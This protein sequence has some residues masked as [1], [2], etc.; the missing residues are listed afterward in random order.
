MLGP[1][2]IDLDT[3]LLRTF[4]AIAESESF[5]QAAETVHRSQAAVSQQMHRLEAML[6][7]DL[8]VK[9]GRSKQLTDQGVT[10]LEYARRILKLNDQAYSALAGG[11]IETT[12]KL[13]ACADAIDTLLPEYLALSTATYPNLDIKIMVGRSRWLARSLQRGD[14]DIMLDVEE[15]PQF[16]SYLLRTSPVVWISG[17]RT[18]HDISNA[19]PL[20]L[21]SIPCVFREMAIHSLESEGK[22]WH[23]TYETTTVASLRAALRA[24]LGI[25]A[26]TIEMLTPDLKVVDKELSLPALPSVSFRLYTRHDDRSDATRKLTDL[27][28]MQ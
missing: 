14:I 22:A 6:N 18:F 20:V 9:S 4:V 27:F 5:A 21:T 17:A 19:V 28:T 12:V 1:K 10:L 16:H 24:G 2:K 23:P 26:R 13:G 25:T 15:H 11:Q 7:C 3:R 8:F